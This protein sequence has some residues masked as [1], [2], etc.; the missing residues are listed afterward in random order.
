MR[1][2]SDPTT[3]L[4]LVASSSFD[5]HQPHSNPNVIPSVLLLALSSL[6]LGHEK[7]WLHIDANLRTKTHPPT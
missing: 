5:S 3:R 2:K 6:D 7:C 1:F 4:N